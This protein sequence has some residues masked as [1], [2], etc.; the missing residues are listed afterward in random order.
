MDW[1]WQKKPKEELKGPKRPKPEEEMLEK[2]YAFLQDEAVQN[3]RL[4][5]A[6]QAEL[7]AAPDVDVVPGATGE[8]GRD[9]NNPIPVNGPF[10]EAQYLSS[11]MTDAGQPIA[12]Q[13]LGSLDRVDLY[14]TVG[15]DGN[16]WDAL[17]LTRYFPRKSRQA[18]KG[19]RFAAESERSVLIRGVNDQ[20]EDFPFGTHDRVVRYTRR[21]LGMPIAD[22]RL[23]S[24]EAV[25]IKIPPEHVRLMER[26]RF[27]V[28]GGSG[29]DG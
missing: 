14:E 7:R 13:R 18:P 6:L 24:L 9:L 2:V 26:L 1:F 5:D 21:I 25:S 4:S 22:P 20:A 19:F 12:F 23:K 29:N 28:T 11:L 17:Y 8:F 16:A 10:G 27:G 3:S 15:L